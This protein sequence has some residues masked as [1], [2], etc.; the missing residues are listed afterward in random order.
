M[1][2]S[3]LEII[4][5]ATNLAQYTMRITTN[6]KRYPAKYITLVQRIQNTCMDIYEFLLDANRLNIKTSK[7]ER[8]E[9]Q[10]R[11][12]NSCD[13]LSCYIEISLN[14]N[15]VGNNTIEHWQKSINDVKYMA[16]AWRN[17]DK[18]R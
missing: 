13:K 1:A 12:I 10:T 16:I 2:E 17:K 7:A 5:M 9:L 18:I 11:A 8:L 6:R 4:I 3:K 15:T 14:L